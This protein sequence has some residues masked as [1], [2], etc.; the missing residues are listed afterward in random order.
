MNVFSVTELNESKYK[1]LLA[2]IKKILISITFLFL[3]YGTVLVIRELSFIP[4]GYINVISLKATKNTFHLFPLPKT[5]LFIRKNHC[6]LIV[7]SLEAKAFD[8]RYK[9]CGCIAYLFTT[10]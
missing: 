2:L 9:Y 1:Q 7:F 4:V 8:L 5:N 6:H 10:M 3:K